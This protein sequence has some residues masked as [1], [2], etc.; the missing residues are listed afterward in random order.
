[1]T[2]TPSFG[3]RQLY[4]TALLLDAICDIDLDQGFWVS[5]LRSCKEEDLNNYFRLDIVSLSFQFPISAVVSQNGTNKSCLV[6]FES[7]KHAF[8]FTLIP[9]GS[10]RGG[11]SELCAL[12]Y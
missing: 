5:C 3:D 6:C 2:R 9:L 10:M 1:M 11:K 12:Q 4:L 8:W 7:E